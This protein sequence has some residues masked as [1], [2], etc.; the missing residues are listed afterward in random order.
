[1]AIIQG[2]RSF[3]TGSGTFL[4][5]AGRHFVRFDLRAPFRVSGI[6]IVW[7]NGAADF[8][9]NDKFYSS[10]LLNP[11]TPAI[12]GSADLEQWFEETGIPFIGAVGAAVGSEVI[13]LANNGARFLLW[14]C[15][16]IADSTVA[17]FTFGT[18]LRSD[19]G[20][21]V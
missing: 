7:E 18:L 13:H 16:P 9:G 6:Q 5:A 11:T 2:Y 17:T 20:E 10:C 15:D 21:V 3:D 4:A 8:G 19:A 1:M 14:E 12:G